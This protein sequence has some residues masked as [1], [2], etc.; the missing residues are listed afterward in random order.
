MVLVLEEI[1][2][3]PGTPACTAGRRATSGL[4]ASVQHPAELY[5]TSCGSLKLFSH[6]LQVM[7]AREK[8]ITHFKPPAL[9]LWASLQLQ[10]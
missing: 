3:G 6:I 8:L 4:S 5:F 9:Y 7:A 1:A 2:A 10:G